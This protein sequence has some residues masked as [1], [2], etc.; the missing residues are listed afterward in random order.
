M[1]DSPDRPIS[2]I[3]PVPPHSGPPCEN[4]P[5]SFATGTDHEGFDP[6][7]RVRHVGPGHKRL[8]EGEKSGRNAS[9]T[10]RGAEERSEEDIGGAGGNTVAWFGRPRTSRHARNLWSPTRNAPMG[11]RAAGGCVVVLPAL[12]EEREERPRNFEVAR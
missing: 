9:T 1:A 2:D 4:N 8:K 3:G 12:D 10:V 7:Q 5:P 6:L 11:C